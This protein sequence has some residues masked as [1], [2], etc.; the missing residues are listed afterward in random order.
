VT[1]GGVKAPANAEPDIK[2]AAAGPR[3]ADAESAS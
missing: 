3:Q 2:D 1:D